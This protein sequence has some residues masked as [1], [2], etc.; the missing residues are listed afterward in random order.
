MV[1][2]RPQ[3]PTC[4]LNGKTIFGFSERV[5]DTSQQ[6]A[7][8]KVWTHFPCLRSRKDGHLS[9][10]CRIENRSYRRIV[11]VAH[12]NFRKQCLCDHKPFPQ[13][14]FSARRN[15][16]AGLMGASPIPALSNQKWLD[17]KASLRSSAALPAVAIIYPEGALIYHKWYAR[18][19]KRRF[20][21]IGAKIPTQKKQ[22]GGSLPPPVPPS[23]CLLFLRRYPRRLAH[24]AILTCSSGSAIPPGTFSVP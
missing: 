18:F 17:G 13:S 11:H 20:A 6:A 14:V 12:F 21:P 2:D 8:G 10:A 9:I 4:W 15:T 24:P 23:A 3:Q 19:C 7:S 16:L 22:T 1:A 5:W